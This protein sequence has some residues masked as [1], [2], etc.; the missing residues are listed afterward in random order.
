[1]LIVRVADPGLRR[2]LVYRSSTE[3]TIL[4]ERQ[5]LTD[6][7]LLPRFNVPISD[8]FSA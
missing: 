6:E 4:D 5:V 7:E 8:L 2:V 1:V 3:V